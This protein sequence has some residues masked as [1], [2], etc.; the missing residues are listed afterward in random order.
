MVTFHRS[1]L[2]TIHCQNQWNAYVMQQELVV[3][4]TNHSLW[5]TSATR[6][7]QSGVDEQ[8]IMGRTGH[9]SIDG[10]RTY[11]QVSNEQ[12]EDI[13]NVLNSATNGDISSQP[14]KIKME[15]SHPQN[16]HHTHSVTIPA[17]RGPPIINLTGCSSITINYT[18]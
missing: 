13:S 10:I 8:L 9:R 4:K 5:V 7:F 3:F 15:Q 12:K 18:K 16:P 1:P 11:K 17:E 2:A 6:L 14:K